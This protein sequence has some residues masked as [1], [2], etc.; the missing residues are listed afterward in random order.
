MELEI[1]MSGVSGCSVFILP[2]FL[3]RTI[4]SLS[5]TPGLP[6]VVNVV[7]SACN[8]WKQQE[9]FFP[10]AS[11]SRAALSG[12]LGGAAGCYR[13]QGIISLGPHRPDLLLAGTWRI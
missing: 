7:G 6:G 2:L 12:Q 13:G 8:V 11:L 4:I 10:A 5:Q 3:T 1:N 9:L